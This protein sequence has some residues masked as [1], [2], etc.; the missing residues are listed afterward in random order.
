MADIAVT[1]D[2]PQDYDADVNQPT[3][4]FECSVVGF[5]VYI[6]IIRDGIIL[7]DWKIRDGFPPLQFTVIRHDHVIVQLPCGTGVM[8]VNRL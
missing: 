3:V 8:T 6:R 4:T 7:C 5:H 1:H 2:T